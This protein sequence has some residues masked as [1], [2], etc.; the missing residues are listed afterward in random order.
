MAESAT[1]ERLKERRLERMRGG[2]ATASVE[3]VPS[4][5]E[6]R[7]ALVPLLEGEYDECMRGAAAVD[8]PENLAGAQVADREEK[9]QVVVRAAREVDDYEK[10][11]FAS[12]VE[13]MNVLEP[14]DVNHLYDCYLEMV[15]QFSPQMTALNQEE[16]D[17][18][19]E[20]LGTLRLNDL[21]GGQV[22]ALSRFLSALQ[23]EQ[24]MGK[25]LGRLSTR[26]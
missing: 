12:T 20:L 10:R 22:Y 6:I 16:I 17:F 15:R 26:S 2:Q 18:L 11:V 3:T 4:D 24:L 1:L 9:R 25:S 8:I 7:I 5:P 23:P 14:T 13:M 19:S 21:S